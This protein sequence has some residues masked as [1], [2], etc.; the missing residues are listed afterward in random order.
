MQLPLLSRPLQRLSL[1]VLTI[2]IP[3]AATA[4]AP[5]P[6][7][8]TAPVP[9]NITNFNRAETDGYFTRTVS[10]G[11]F[12]KILHNRDVTPIARQ[13]APRSNRDTLYSAGVFDLEAAPVTVTLP[14]TGRRFMSMEVISEDH[15]VIEVVYAPGRFSYTPNKIGTRYMMLV[16]RTAV[17]ADSPQDARAAYALQDAVRVEQA[18]AGS[19][20]VPNWD[21]KS[22]GEARDALVVLASLGVG[23]A[24]MFGGKSE[25]DPVA[26]LIGTAVAW[27]GNPRR[28]RLQGCVSGPERRSDRAQ[29]HGEGCPCRRLLVHQRLQRQGLL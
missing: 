28:C 1:A 6:N 18:S 7:P 26:H 12:G 27:G 4:Q 16:I 11:A 24:I 23:R 5:N 9:V 17:D 29:A 21:A 14:D 19:F 13:N 3:P 22:I 15:Y 2:L 8:D 20:E 25:V 10:E